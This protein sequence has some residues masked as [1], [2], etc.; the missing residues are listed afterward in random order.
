MN[1]VRLH[2]FSERQNQI[3]TRIIVS[4]AIY[5]ISVRWLLLLLFSVWFY[6]SFSRT[7]FFYEIRYTI[8]LCDFNGKRKTK[9]FC[10]LERNKSKIGK[11]SRNRRNALNVD[12][13]Q[14]HKTRRK[15]KKMN[16]TAKKC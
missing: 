9:N 14:L 10:I 12:V 2:F 1:A 5:S 8:L 11:S 4:V 15:R 16:K 3:H 13:L 7:S 6:S